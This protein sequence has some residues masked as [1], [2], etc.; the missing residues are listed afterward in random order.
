MRRKIILIKKLAFAFVLWHNGAKKQI[1][2]NL[3]LKIK[4]LEEFRIIGVD[5]YINQL[6][7]KLLRLISFNKLRIFFKFFC[8]VLK[9]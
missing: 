4:I 9:Q 3:K 1:K 8:L 6:D 5:L 2:E 7:A